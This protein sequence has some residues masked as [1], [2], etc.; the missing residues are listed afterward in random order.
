MMGAIHTIRPSSQVWMTLI[1]PA[2]VRPPIRSR[3]RFELTE[4]T[5]SL[6]Q[7]SRLRL[8]REQDATA[9]GLLLKGF[10]EVS[11]R[12]LLAIALS[13]ITTASAFVAP[14]A[15]TQNPSQAPDQS[16]NDQ[17]ADS[18]IIAIPGKAAAEMRALFE[19]ALAADRAADLAD[20]FCQA[21]Q[22]EKEAKRNAWIAAQFKVA[23]QLSVP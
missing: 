22:W 16:V 8:L 7:R 4:R 15:I 21:R 5:T 23:R 18:R 11:M 20:Q 9:C 12:L 17:R 2:L 6:I 14:G 1:S 19:Q 13:I 10:S 3:S